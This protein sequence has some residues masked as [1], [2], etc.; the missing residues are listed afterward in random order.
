MKP[1]SLLPSKMCLPYSVPSTESTRS[2]VLCTSTFTADFSSSKVCSYNCFNRVRL[3]VDSKFTFPISGDFSGAK[4]RLKEAAAYRSDE[5]V[6]VDNCV[7]GN[8]K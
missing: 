2:H 7:Y 6:Y 3:L 4:K 8:T 5:A 1:P